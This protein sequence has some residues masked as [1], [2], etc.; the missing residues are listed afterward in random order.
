LIPKALPARRKAFLDIKGH[1]LPI[2]SATVTHPPSTRQHRSAGSPTFPPSGS[3]TFNI[4]EETSDSIHRLSG[5][6]ISHHT[7]ASSFV[8]RN[9]RGNR[10]T[11]RYSVTAM[12]SMAAEQDVEV[13]DELA[14][15]EFASLLLP[16]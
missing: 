11:N 7:T 14:R 10:M 5:S 6:T 3:Q 9:R 15:G 4:G 12:Y 8:I 16:G 2:M 1:L 13:E